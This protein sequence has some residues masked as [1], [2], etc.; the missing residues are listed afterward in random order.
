MED[1]QE[2][3]SCFFFPSAA[4]CVSHSRAAPHPAAAQFNISSLSSRMLAVL[5]LALAAASA[6]TVYLH[7]YG[8]SFGTPKC[9]A[10]LPIS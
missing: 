5:A 10:Q 8:N 2:L 6:Q 3:G 7:S 4:T 1:K 9:V